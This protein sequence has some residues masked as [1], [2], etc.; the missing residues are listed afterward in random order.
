MARISSEA[1]KYPTPTVESLARA[2]RTAGL[3]ALSPA[4]MDRLVA[5]LARQ[6]E[7]DLKLMPV[8]P[9]RR[10]SLSEIVQYGLG[11]KKGRFYKSYKHLIKKDGRRSYVLG[12]DLLALNDTA[13]TVVAR[14]VPEQR[15]QARPRGRPRKIRLQCETS[16]EGAEAPS[17]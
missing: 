5:R 15:S 13:P 3:D 10:Y 1:V 4:E 9:D 16:G 6:I 7:H 2:V 11:P 8:C 17:V 14:P 12:R